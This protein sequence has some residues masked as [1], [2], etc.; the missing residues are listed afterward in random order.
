MML[1]RTSCPNVFLDPNSAPGGKIFLKLAQ[2]GQLS[3]CTIIAAGGQLPVFLRVLNEKT[4]RTNR[5]TGIS[6]D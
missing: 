2:L 3:F 5:H 6:R 4:E 1:E